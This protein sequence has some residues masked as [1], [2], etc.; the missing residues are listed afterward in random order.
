VASIALLAIAV[1]VQPGTA[2]AASYQQINLVSDV[3][4]QADR[5]D[6]KL[7]NPRGIA[8]VPNGN[9]WVA[10]NG[11]GVSTIYHA[12][13]SPLSLVVT[14]P[15]P[16]GSTDTAAPTGIVFNATPDFMVTADSKTGASFFLFATEDGTISGWS[17]QVSQTQAVLAVDRSGSHAVYKG[18]ALGSNASGNFLYA[19][20]FYAAAIDVFDKDFQPASLP[21]SFAD[22][23]IPAGFAPFNIQNLRGKL[24][25]AYAK[26][27]AA[28]QDDVPGPGNGYVDVFDTDGH[29]LQRLVSQGPL[30][31]PWGLARAPAGFG[32][33]SH[34]LLIGNFGDG[35][36]NAFDPANGHFLGR[37][38][39]ADGQPIVIAGLWALAFGKPFSR[40]LYFTAG[41]DDEAHGLFGKIIPAS[42]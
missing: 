11:T 18:L 12:D 13:G 7:V 33:F 37:L 42:R 26:Q 39:G 27:D 3:P 21:G 24:Y 20:N 30:D 15:P 29:L 2:R 40:S 35:R 1:V 14:V 23:D 36:I 41:I 32:K 31:S 5:T 22:P 9:L 16:T 10:D 34:A 4:G 8:V 6:P 19:A 28:K 17:P 38:K 25:V